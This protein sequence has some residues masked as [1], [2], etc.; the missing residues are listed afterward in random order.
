MKKTLIYLLLLLGVQSSFSQLNNQFHWKGKIG[1]YPISMNLFLDTNTEA[2]SYLGSYYYHSEEIPISISKKKRSADSLILYIES[3]DD[4][5]EVFKGVLKN[6]TYKGVWEKGNKKLMFNLKIHPQKLYLEMTRMEKSKTIPAFMLADSTSIQAN[7]KFDWIL[8]KE[9][10]LQT[11]LVENLYFS[12]EDVT[13]SQ[14]DVF[15]EQIIEQLEHEYLEEVNWFLEEYKDSE[16]NYNPYS[17]NHSYESYFYP[18]MNTP[19]YL[20]MVYMGYEYTGGAH[21]IAYRKFATFDKKAKQWLLLSDILDLENEEKILKVLDKKIRNDYKLADD[22]GLSE[23]DDSIFIVNKVFL[24]DNFTLSKKGITFHYGLY[25]MTPY[26]YGF[27]ELFV[28]YKDLEPY[29]NKQFSY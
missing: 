15:T 17:F 2:F 27:F 12:N 25:D 16:D 8:P 28:P 23:S 13:Y 4:A 9:Q 1:K 18:L 10:N 21:G 3:K 11:Y 19:K 29:I 22:I 14:F 20:H 26:V 5:I 24:S 7:Y 6:K